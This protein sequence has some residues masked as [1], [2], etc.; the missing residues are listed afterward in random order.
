MKVDEK[1]W[2]ARNTTSLYQEFLVME[3]DR[4]KVLPDNNQQVADFTTQSEFVIYSDIAKNVS[5]EVLLVINKNTVF[6]GKNIRPP[7][8]YAIL[9]VPYT[10]LFESSLRVNTFSIVSLSSHQSFWIQNSLSKKLAEQIKA[11]NVGAQPDLFVLDEENTIKTDQIKKIKESKSK[12][13]KSME[14][15]IEKL[16]EEVASK[17]IENEN[18]S[19]LIKLKKSEK[20]NAER[21]K[22]QNLEKYNRLLQELNFDEN[23]MK[24]EERITEIHRAIER[25]RKNRDKYVD[26]LSEIIRTELENYQT[27]GKSQS[28]A[29]EALMEVDKR[30]LAEYEKEKDKLAKKMSHL[31]EKYRK[32]KEEDR[33]MINKMNKTI[34][35][36]TFL[37]GILNSEQ[38]SIGPMEPIGKQSCLLCFSGTQ[39]V[40][41]LDC[42]HLSIFCFKCFTQTKQKQCKYC[43]KPIRKTL[44]LN[45]IYPNIE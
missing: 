4:V 9:V 22:L 10:L 25:E 15:S 17:R 29:N 8:H 12:H 14:E 5:N 18:L 23:M 7:S 33:V 31:K 26:S 28:Q 40:L 38:N 43:N 16:S 41:L 21:E 44:K 35:K 20:L 39:N 19:E 34:T 45:F 6:I 2:L 30:K 3:M 13:M 27:I 37:E 24:Y 1:S 11:E 36:T 32:L 42:G